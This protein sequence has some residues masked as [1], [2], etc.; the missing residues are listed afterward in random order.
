MRVLRRAA[1]GSGRG[2]RHTAQFS[3]PS[4][5]R[6]FHECVHGSRLRDAGRL[7]GY[8]LPR[9]V[10]P[11]QRQLSADAPEL[12]KIER[13]D[14]AAAFDDD[15]EVAAMFDEFFLADV[16]VHERDYDLFDI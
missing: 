15:D 1:G 3:L 13:S 11:A 16:P 10:D 4:L 9:V 8:A 5:R 6:V 12:C 14:G 7:C 2:P